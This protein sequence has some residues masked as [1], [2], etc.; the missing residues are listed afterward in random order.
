MTARHAVAFIVLLMLA[1]WSAADELLMK[2]GSRL[3]GK[4]VSASESEVIFDTPFAGQLKVQQANIV[5]V[6]ADQKEL[7]DVAEVH[8]AICRDT[9]LTLLFDRGHALDERIAAEQFMV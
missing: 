4:L 8:I 7:R 1:N 9:P 2:N 3:I 6:V 5:S